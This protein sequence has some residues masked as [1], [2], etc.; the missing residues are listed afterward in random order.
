MDGNRCP[1]DKTM[2]TF[3]RSDSLHDGT[4]I[5]L[6]RTNHD[7]EGEMTS[8]EASIA[9]TWWQVGKRILE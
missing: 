5:G 1:E 9:L 7:R 8:F 2:W 4:P 3:Y 6:F